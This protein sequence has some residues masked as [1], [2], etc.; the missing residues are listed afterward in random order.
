[1]QH[2]TVARSSVRPSP[3]VAEL[4]LDSGPPGPN[5]PSTSREVSHGCTVLLLASAG[6]IVVG[7]LVVKN[8]GTSTIP[9]LNHPITGYRDGLLLAMAA[10]L[11][12]VID[13]LVVGSLSMRRTRRARRTQ[14]RRTERELSSQLLELERENTKLRDELARRD[15]A[16]RRLAG[17]PAAADLEPPGAARRTP[18]PLADRQ[19]ELIYE[20]ARRVAHLRSH[21]DLPFLSGY[22]RSGTA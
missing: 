16:A 9:V 15:S 8:T 7:D 17:V 4:I 5:E 10:A 22:T 21:S 6:A 12:L 11:G 13:L 20:E 14:L 3:A 19:V 18:S 1:M 2:A